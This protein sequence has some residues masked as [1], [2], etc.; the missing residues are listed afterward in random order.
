MATTGLT[1]LELVVSA[2]TFAGSKAEIDASADAALQQFCAFN[3]RHRG[4][5]DKLHDVLG[6]TVSMPG[7]YCASTTSPRNTGSD[8]RL[9]FRCSLLV[10]GSLSP[11]TIV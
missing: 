4:L 10:P 11:C 7:E 1:V 3:S 2:P 8:P 6:D 5:A 9:H